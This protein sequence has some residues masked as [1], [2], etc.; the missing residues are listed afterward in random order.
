MGR[1]A[2]GLEDC[3]T[4]QS[5]VQAVTWKNWQQY[6]DRDLLRS[7]IT[8]AIESELNGTDGSLCLNLGGQW[9]QHVPRIHELL[10]QFIPH[11]T[12]C[13]IASH[14][15]GGANYDS[16]SAQDLILDWKDMN[17]TQRILYMLKVWNAVHHCE[18]AFR[19][20]GDSCISIAGVVAVCY[21]L[22]VP[23]V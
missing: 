20:T 4:S 22:K 19:R 8:V 21:I 18:P 5:P 2:I 23:T 6:V 13:Y 12:V 9:V 17:P 14:E 1:K 7:A 10:C 11:N 3:I 16:Y 15:N